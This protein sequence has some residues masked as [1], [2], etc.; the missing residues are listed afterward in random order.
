MNEATVRRPLIVSPPS[1][2]RALSDN[3]YKLHALLNSNVQKREKQAK[4]FI[5]ITLI[6]FEI[7]L[8]I[9]GSYGIIDYAKILT[10]SF[11]A[12]FVCLAAFF[13]VD[14]HFNARKI[15]QT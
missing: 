8:Y 14:R 4:I 5:T 6:L 9:T 7:F 13:G 3:R 15:A 11:I 12:L 10:L 2:C 1:F